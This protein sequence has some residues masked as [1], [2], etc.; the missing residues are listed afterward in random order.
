[1]I[2]LM[3]AVLF[4]ITGADETT[5]RAHVPTEELYEQ[6]AALL[7]ED[8]LAEADAIGKRIVRTNPRSAITHRHLAELYEAHAQPN[9]A[10]K[11]LR[12]A[13]AFDDSPKDHLNL[14]RLL[15]KEGRPTMALEHLEEAQDLGCTEADL[16]AELGLAYAR[17][18]RDVGRTRRVTIEG[19]RVGQVT[20]EWYLLE[21]VPDER[22]TFVAAP[23][24]CAI[25]QLELAQSRGV[26][27]VDVNC[28]LAKVWMRRG[29]YQRAEEI[30]RAM[31][32]RA[33]ADK[34][35]DSVRADYYITHAE[36]VHGLDDMERYVALMSQAAKLDPKL[37]GPL[38]TKAYRKA[39]DRFKQRGDLT[40]Y[41]FYLKQFLLEQPEDADGHYDLGI[42]YLEDG[43]PDLAA[44]HLQMSLD[45]P[46]NHARRAQILELLNSIQ[47]Q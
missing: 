17:I 3:L 24:R 18:G 32:K 41:I 29:N 47:S 13:L 20:G 26:E 15:S 28:E 35:P 21:R 42:A 36:A 14:G 44:Q 46:S 11:H 43:K 7:A 19:G 12:S 9:R 4:F 34:L 1:M 25:Y 27:R 38:L 22:D 6:I 2:Q 10:I 45:L 39:A 31:S 37:A 33:D 16:S 23:R 8:K 5:P 30:C 40:Q